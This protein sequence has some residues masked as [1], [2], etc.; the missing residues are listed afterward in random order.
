MSQENVEVVRSAFDAL[1]QGGVDAGMAYVTDDCEFAPVEAALS[2]PMS[3]IAAIRAYLQ[4]FF[5]TFDD[6]KFELP[7]V[8]DAGSGRVVAV[9]SAS[10]RAKLTGIETDL[11]YA[12]LYTVRGG[13]IA[14]AYEYPTRA[15]ALG[16][17]GMS[18]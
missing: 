2:G 3:G 12:G 16:A 8:L 4:E 18:E 9:V 6:F 14:G 15:E 11:T 1:N 7:E 17:A 13:K 5:D 10:G